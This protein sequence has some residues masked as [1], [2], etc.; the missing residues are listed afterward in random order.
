[1]NRGSKDPR[2]CKF[3]RVAL[4]IWRKTTVAGDHL[5]KVRIE[6]MMS[7]DKEGIPGDEVLQY[8]TQ[9]SFE[10]SFVKRGLVSSIQVRCL[11][12]HLLIAALG[13]GICTT[14]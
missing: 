3:S 2:S 1:M 13:N 11:M 6:T 4:L 12:S 7:G 8:Y 9:M 14:D 10:N 5:L